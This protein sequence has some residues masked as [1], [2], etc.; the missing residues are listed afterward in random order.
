LFHWFP[1]VLGNLGNLGNPEV[2]GNLGNLGNPEDP[3]DP[4]YP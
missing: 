2:L 4:Y 3:L 1:E